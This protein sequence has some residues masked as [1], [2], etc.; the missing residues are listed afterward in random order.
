[1]KKYTPY[2]YMLIDLANQ[3]GD[4]KISFEDRIEKY[5]DWESLDFHKADN[6]AQAEACLLALKDIKEGRPTGYMVA[7]DAT[8]SGWQLLSDALR[9]L[10][11]AFCTN[12]VNINKENIFNKYIDTKEYNRIDGYTLVHKIFKDKFDHKDSSI[13][14]Q[15]IK[16]SIMQRIYGGKAKCKEVFGDDYTDFEETMNM[17][18]PIVWWFI[19]IVQEF[20]KDSLYQNVHYSWVMPDNFHVEMETE[21]TDYTDFKCITPD[22]EKDTAF[23]HKVTGPNKYYKGLVANITHSL[24][25]LVMREMLIRCSYK[26]N[27]RNQELT[28][29]KT[30]EPTGMLKTLLDHYH[31]TGFLSARVLDCLKGQEDTLTV[32]ETKAINDLIKSLPERPFEL[33]GIHDSYHCSPNNAQALREQMKNILVAI[34]DANILQDVM[35]Q[36]GINIKLLPPNDSFTNKVRNCEYAI[37]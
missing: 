37:C 18:S 30:K 31:R 10:L 16:E 25:S 33:L 2:Q 17:C 9:D 15:P 12:T 22:G 24:D 19:N 23:G 27:Y 6:P 20:F 13:S 35:D 21:Y 14:R 34:A 3:F 32:E 1:M 11:G 5:K 36:L 28:L 29:P 26:T 4:D 7:L 8:C